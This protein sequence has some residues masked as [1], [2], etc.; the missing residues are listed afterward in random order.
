[1]RTYGATTSLL[2]IKD[3]QADNRSLP[4]PP[5]LPMAMALFVL[6]KAQSVFLAL[7]HDGLNTRG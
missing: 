6:A 3:L 7:M 5:T 1:M 2:L 4:N